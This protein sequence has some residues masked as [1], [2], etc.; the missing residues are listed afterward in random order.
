M[1]WDP[2]HECMDREELR[3]LQLK[4]LKETVTRVYERVPF[5]R[6]A[7][8][9][10]GVLP[11]DIQS[12]ADVTRLPFTDKTA[13]RD[14]YPYGLFALP[15]K[16]IVR[17]HA[18]SGTTGKPTVVGY[19]RRDLENW[20]NLVARVVTM[21][22]VTDEDVV[23]ITFGYGLFTGAFGLH[24]G[25]E[26]VGVTLVPASVGNTTRQIMLMQD[27]G[28]TALVGTPSY[29][30][31]LAD[32]ARGLGIDPASLGIRTGLF[33]AEAWTESMRAELERTWNMKA[34]DNYGLSEVM[35]PGVAGEC[36]HFAGQ[37]I[38]ED[39]FLVEIIDPETGEQLPPGQEGELV[40]TTL[41]KEALPILRYRTRD[42]TVI[43][44]E[45]CECGRTLARMRKIRGRTDDMLIISGVNVFPSQIETV[46]MNIDGL[47]PHYQILVNKK[48]YLDIME[49]QVELTDEMFT[50][51]F[52]DLEALESKIRQKIFSVL[53]INCKVRLLEPRS[54]ARSEGK[55]KRVIDNRPKE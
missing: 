22:G 23:Q 46:L 53:S 50:G 25:L 31:H 19:S 28:A 8:D 40:I 48:G 34:T 39:H 33:G 10:A 21:A 2:Q 5:Y 7:L 36:L 18:S 32:T 12:L 55:I 54:L 38:N 3:S 29:A 41:T 43:N 16:Q 9:R 45:K 26:K 30:L 20:S 13:L 37:H 35:G 4:R 52:R 24:Y 6:Q 47:S 27:F 14:N 51:H 1:I 15:K 49:V 17:L 44:E 11:G 42:I